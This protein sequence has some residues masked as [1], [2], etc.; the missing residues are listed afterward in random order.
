MRY[1]RVANGAV[2]EII[3]TPHTGRALALAFHSDVVRALVPAPNPQVVPGWLALPGGEFAPPPRPATVR[4]VPREVT[5]FQARAVMMG[6]PGPGGVSLFAAV[7]AA[8][9]A[10]GGFAWQAWEY[11]NTITREGALVTTMATQF[12]LSDDQ[13]DELFIAAA[14]VEA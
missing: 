8:V 14:T 3:E 9:R 1:A 7:D 10:E 11:A 5:N 4:V 13:L 2:A 6:Q 12:G